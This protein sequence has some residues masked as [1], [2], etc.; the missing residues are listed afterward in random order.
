[1]T[2]KMSFKRIA[3][4]VLAVS[5]GACGTSFDDPGPVS[6]H[7]PG[8][9]PR[10]LRGGEPLQCVPYARDNSGVRLWGDASTWWSKASGKFERASEPERGAVMVVRGYDSDE[11]GHVAVVRKILSDREIVVDHANWLNS[12]EISLDN[13][14]MDVSDDNDWSKVRVWYAP[15]GHYGGRVYEV[16]GFILDPSDGRRVASR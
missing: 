8:A 5:L 10:V 6:W 13:P 11:R 7:A 3:I 16:R 12:G 9:K 4:A 1:M 15:G 2:S 14:V